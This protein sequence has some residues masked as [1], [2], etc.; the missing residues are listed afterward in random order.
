MLDETLTHHRSGKRTPGPIIITYADDVTIILRPRDE[1]QHVREP[2]RIY[3]AASGAR[4][5]L[6]KSQATALGSWDTSID[7]MGIPYE[8]EL[9]YLGTK[10]TSTMRNSAQRSWSVVTGLLKKHAQDAYH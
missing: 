2:L 5:N 6:N 7:V 3:E 8:T 1:I 10:M 9:S 4:L